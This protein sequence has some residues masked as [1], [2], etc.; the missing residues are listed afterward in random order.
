[1]SILPSQQSSILT[2][3]Q[4]IAATRLHFLKQLCGYDEDTQN[5]IAARPEPPRRDLHRPTEKKRATPDPR[6]GQN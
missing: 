4:S 6:P 3:L 2:S 5:N 1:L